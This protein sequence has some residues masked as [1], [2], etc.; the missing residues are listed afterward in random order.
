MD[1]KSYCF[2]LQAIVSGQRI[3]NF[4]LGDWLCDGEEFGDRVYAAAARATGLPVSALRSISSVSKRVSKKVRN[5]KLSWGHH[6]LVQSFSPDRQRMLLQEAE[7]LLGESD[8][9]AV[10][11]F[12]EKIEFRFPGTFKRKRTE[13]YRRFCFEI[14]EAQFLSL[15]KLADAKRMTLTD[16]IAQ[17]VAQHASSP[18]AQA[19]LQDAKATRDMRSSE[20]RKK[21]RKRWEAA[22]IRSVEAIVEEVQ[23]SEP[24]CVDGAHVVRTWRRRNGG[25]PFPLALAQK[26]TTFG[27]HCGDQSAEDLQCG[28]FEPVDADL[29]FFDEDEVA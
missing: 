29:E 3:A 13:P 19:A 11:R 12:R 8:A 5:K 25:K 28:K 4:K 1:F 2:G 24:G 15:E 21:G 17:V 22:T 10:N 6:R 7:P 20:N 18:F 16:Y 23:V 14:P 26:R 9:L 27:D